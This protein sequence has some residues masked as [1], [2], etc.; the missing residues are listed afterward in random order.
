MTNLPTILGLKLGFSPRE[1]DFNKDLTQIH[2]K[3]IDSAEKR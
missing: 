1:N 3:T 2:L